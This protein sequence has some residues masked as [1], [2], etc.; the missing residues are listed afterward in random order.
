M[1]NTI[2]LLMLFVNSIPLFATRKEILINENWKFRFWHQVQFKSE[3]RVDLPH[4]W[5]AQDALAGTQDYFRGIG[6]Y[7]KS[8]FINPEWEGKRLYLRFEGVNTIANVF[9]NDVHLGE[10]RG[11][12]GAFVFEITDFVRYNAENKLLVKVNNALQL[13]I[14]PLVGDFNFYGGIYRDV[15][16]IITE[17]IHI[18]LT[19]YASPGVYLVQEKVTKQDAQVKA[20][21][22]LA[23]NKKIAEEAELLLTVRD[24]DKIIRQ[25]KQQVTVQPGDRNV[26]SLDFSILNPRLWNGTKDPFM[27][28][29]EVVILQNGIEKDKIIQPLGLRYYHIDANEG[30]FL[31]GEHLKLKGVCRYQDR[32]ERGNAL[33][34]E[35]HEEDAAIMVEMGS[36]AV[37]LA[38]Y[39][40]AT[41]FY[42][43]MDK[44]GLITWAEIPFIGPGGYQDRGY[45]NQLSFRENGK[46]QL[47]EL[48]RQHYNHPSICFW[49]LYNELK[50]I[51]DN[52][53]DYIEE[54]NGLAHQEDPTR[55]TTSASFLP[56][57]NTL[58]AVTD[59]IAWNQYFGWYGGSPSDMGKWADEVHRDFPEFKIGISEYG[60]GASIYHQQ[61]S[62][63]RGEA[64]GWWH[65]ENYQ[66]YYHIGNWQAIAERPFIWGSFIWNLFDFGAAHRTEGDRPGINDKGLVTFDRKVKKDAFYFYK[67]NWNTTEKFVYISNRRHR[68]RTQPQT[69][70]T[71]FSN[72]PEV[73]LFINGVS[74]GKQRPDR[75]ATFIWQEC[76]LREGE[77]T[78]EARATGKES[79]LINDKVE[80]VLK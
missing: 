57:K 69:N 1:K 15:N 48:I 24:G 56:H 10:H 3:R 70:I 30:F 78:I 33:Y 73:E 18:S 14:M 43:L 9:M 67:A 71:I 50:T 34:K 51:G 61:D 65:P 36:N 38:H 21:V 26:V 66:T 42:E 6:N 68:D 37:R 60:A 28:Q 20:N 77:N 39:P 74:Q 55:P 64:T 63:K 49:G 31:N 72:L 41:Y 35:H 22:V 47:K 8:L 2:I 75:Y 53:L 13:D 46:E 76:L 19:D 40:Q 25:E 17:P 45:T 29:T 27:Y 12:Y 16:L 5:N 52:P 32:A 59:L 44:Y 54:L 23:N 4:T 80:W 7:E 79:R 11:G 58:N 62:V